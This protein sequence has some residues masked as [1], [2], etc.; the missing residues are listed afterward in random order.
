VNTLCKFYATAGLAATLFTSSAFAQRNLDGEGIL[1]QGF[2]WNS[3]RIDFS[4]DP[5][6]SS[7]YQYMNS[8]VDELR[9]AGFNGIWMPPPWSDI[10]EYTD[11]Q[12]P[13]VHGGGEG[14]FWGAFDLNSQYGSEN[15][16]RNLTKN[17][18]EK[19]ITPIFDAVIN[20][21]DT[22][23]WRWTQTFDYSK[24]FRRNSWENTCLDG[25]SI[26]DGEPF[27]GGDADLCLTKPSV[28][29]KLAENLAKLTSMGGN[30]FRFDFVKGY[31]PHH[32]D[33]FMNDAAPDGFCVAELWPSASIGEFKKEHIYPYSKKSKCN[34]F[35]FVLKYNMSNHNIDKWKKGLLTD[36]DPEVRSR[37]VTFVDNHDTGYSPKGSVRRLSGSY[38]DTG[39]GQHHWPTNDR[40]RKQAYAYILTSPGT[41]VVFWPHYFE[42]GM[43]NSIDQYISL[44]K[45]AGITA[46]STV[47]HKDVQNGLEYTTI[48]SKGRLDV[49]ITESDISIDLT[50]KSQPP[51][52]QANATKITMAGEVQ[53]PLTI[54]DDLD[55]IEKIDIEIIEQEKVTTKVEKKDNSV[56]II[57]ITPTESGYDE[58]LISA[59]DTSGQ[60]SYIRLYLDIDMTSP[61]DWKRTVVFVYGTTQAGQDMF[62]RG[63]IDHE[64]AKN[65]LGVDCS[66]SGM[67]CAIPIRHL[68][69]KNTTTADWKLEDDFL[70]WYGP[71]QGQMSQSFGTPM[72]WTTNHWPWYWGFSRQY[73]VDG[74]GIH[75]LNQWGQHYWVMDVEMDCSKTVDG[76]FEFKTFILNGDGW[77]QDINQLDAPYQS[78]NHFARCGMVNKF[79]R[80]S[81]NKFIFNIN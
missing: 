31:A 74:Y 56:A 3:V 50:L 64:Y 48:G 69:Y 20:H 8:K 55:G 63:G 46:S 75:P 81:G 4:N 61:S 15:D 43:K 47:I 54:T 23:R 66:V 60:V 59:T 22:G 42:W 39:W 6:N 68:N 37:A 14:Y 67:E 25:Y 30:G 17:L 21:A 73:S 49:K 71:E 62:I 32:I 36:P 44:R 28:K 80:N 1:I 53:I 13:N 76:W 45:A 70:D 16:L 77:E 19:G 18:S 11:Y 34:M 79:E 40:L 12:N 35:D 78:R 72:D 58:I 65:T 41:P 52:I 5:E 26:D 57:T 29:E 24:D 2:H 27:M 33:D 7:W 9:A 51:V 10:S 38:I